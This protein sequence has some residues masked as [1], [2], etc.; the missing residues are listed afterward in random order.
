LPL[1][2]D[3]EEP[4][5][6]GWGDTRLAVPAEPAGAGTWFDVLSGAEVV[7]PPDGRLDVARL[8]GGFPVA[9]LVNAPDAAH[10]G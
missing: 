3:G 8:L 6:R 5:P 2:G 10:R 7:V 1:L 4:L 9:L